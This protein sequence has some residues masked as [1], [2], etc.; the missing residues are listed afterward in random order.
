MSYQPLTAEQVRKLAERRKR[1][2]AL[3]R[4]MQRDVEV[5]QR[6][7]KGQPAPPQDRYAAGADRERSDQ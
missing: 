1:G 3:R 4:K 5:L 7:I 2:E 6:I